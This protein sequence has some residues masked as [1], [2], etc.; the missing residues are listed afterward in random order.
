MNSNF[1]VVLINPT[2]GLIPTEFYAPT[3]H[4]GLAY[5]TAVLRKNSFP[6][7]I[8]DAYALNL[9]YD[10]VVH[11]ALAMNPRYI[12]I[13]AE[14]NTIETAIKLIR[15][16]RS[17][18]P[19]VH[20][21]LGGQHATFSS[22]ELFADVLELDSIIRGEGE[23]TIVEVVTR[24]SQGQDLTGVKGVYFRNKQ[25]QIIKNCDRAAIENLDSLPFPARDTLEDCLAKGI[26]PAISILT[27]RGCYANCSFCNA[28]KYFNLGG[29]RNW[30]SRSP[31]SV[32]IEIQHLLELYQE[33]PIYEILYFNDENFIGPGEKGIQRAVKIAQEILQRNLNIFFEIFCRAD[34]FNGHEEA[35]K[36]LSKAGLISVLV[37][38]ESGYQKGLNN[39]GKGTTVNQNLNT[40]EL[41]KKY[42][43]ITS[44]SGFLMFNPYS[45]FE[46]LEQNAK[47]LLAIGM[48]T[49]YNMSLRVLG[50]PGIRMV[51][52]LE[53]E[54]LLAPD[55]GH[56]NVSSYR[57]KDSRISVL[58]EAL[59]F[60]Y[61]LGRKEDAAH[62]YLDF[63]I[64]NIDRKVAKIKLDNEQESEV[65]RLKSKV[66]DLCFKANLVTYNFFIKALM[67]CENNW[68][69][70]VFEKLINKYKIEIAEALE[71]MNNGFVEYLGGLDEILAQDN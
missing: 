8:I 10:E 15:E 20:L 69:Q 71:E 39:F 25:G 46:E 55:F 50:Y 42:N 6:V 51:K 23:L 7:K 36:T 44:S 32:V 4:L 48:A 16:F 64:T 40:I 24:L 1:Q 13:T 2:N 19:E 57:F 59:N 43:I 18:N 9:S 70:E 38:L 21:A 28:S 27:S 56:L 60:D 26:T 47:F 61:S 52:I 5:L 30:R 67:I 62:R 49:L 54:G 33:K 3:E 63:M 58:V 45:T 68:G 12:G 34:S 17:K 14:Y 11:Y 35:V 66:N 37:G 31:E 29:G 22:L 41:F 65:I 53:N